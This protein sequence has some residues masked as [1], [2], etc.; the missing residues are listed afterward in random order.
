MPTDKDTIQV[1][2]KLNRLTQEGKLKWERMQ[3]PASLTSGTDSKVFD[4]YGT[5][6]KG[7]NI[8][9][10]EERYQAFDDEY[11]HRSYWTDK[12]V[13]AFFSDEWQKEWE[14]PIGAGVLEL[15]TSVKYQIA[16]VDSFISDLLEDGGGK[17]EE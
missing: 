14:F 13:L 11:F 15:L 16:G 1:I 17:A 5:R 2:T 9:L 8:G 4:F 6:Y 12:E 7:R 3:P 10:Y